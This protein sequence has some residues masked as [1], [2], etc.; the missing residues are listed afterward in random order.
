MQNG[1]DMWV[2]RNVFFL[3]PPNNDLS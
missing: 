3:I 2:S 1:I